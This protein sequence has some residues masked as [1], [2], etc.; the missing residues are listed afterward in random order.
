M[1]PQTAPT[2]Q[3][4]RTQP[5]RYRRCTHCGEVSENVCEVSEYVGGRGYVTSYKCR[6]ARACWQR[7]DKANGLVS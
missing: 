6:D 1:L 2:R 3:T 5:R 7:W 4:P